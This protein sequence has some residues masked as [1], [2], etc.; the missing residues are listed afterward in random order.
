MLLT[1][2]FII[3]NL[4]L[5]E[6][7]HFFFQIFNK[8]LQLIPL[9]SQFLTRD[10]RLTQSLLVSYDRFFVKYRTFTQILVRFVLAYNW[11]TLWT[12]LF[13]FF[14]R[15]YSRISLEWKFL[16]FLYWRRT[17]AKISI[18]TLLDFILSGQVLFLNLSAKLFQRGNRL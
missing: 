17:V 18:K 14:G 3:L 11:G 4:I 15:T 10:S 5:F 16:V 12:V 7:V 8:I 13:T 6:W 1:L 9:S 2:S